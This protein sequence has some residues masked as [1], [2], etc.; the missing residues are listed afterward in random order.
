[1]RLYEDVP[2]GTEFQEHTDG[3]L[4]VLRGAGATLTPW[5]QTVAAEYPTKL[6]LLSVFASQFK[7]PSI[8]PGVKRSAHLG[9]PTGPIERLWTLKSLPDHLPEDEL[10]VGA[11]DVERASAA[12]SRFRQ[13][14]GVE[15]RLAVFAIGAAGRWSEDLKLLSDTFPAAKFVVYAGPR[16]CAELPLTNTRASSSTALT[17]GRFPGSAQ[18]CARYQPVI[19]L[20]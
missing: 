11:A 12:L 3:I 2:Y 1:M 19:E 5:F 9:S 6:A 8:E 20:S 13:G 16:V 18:L 7:A 10:W 15:L 14:A 4:N 17:V